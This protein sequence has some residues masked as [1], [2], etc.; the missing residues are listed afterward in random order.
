MKDDVGHLHG[1]AEGDI[2]GWDAGEWHHVVVT[3]DADRVLLY[4]DAIEQTRDDEGSRF[5]DGVIALPTG[6]QTWINLGWRF[7]NWY[8][9]AAIVCGRDRRALLGRV[10]LSR[11]VPRAMMFG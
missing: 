10:I 5:G 3:W 9:N 11:S 2:A 1:T 8:C 7:G 4:L 6:E